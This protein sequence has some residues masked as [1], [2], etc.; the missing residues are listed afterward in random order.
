MRVSSLLLLAAPLLVAASCPRRDDPCRRKSSQERCLWLQGVAN[1]EPRVDESDHGREL[2]NES[3]GPSTGEPAELE[4][5]MTDVVEIMRFGLEWRLVDQRARELCRTR[6][7][8]GALVPADVTLAEDGRPAWTCPVAGLELDGEE[9]LLEASAGVIS[10]SSL[11]LDASR[12]DALFDL[13]RARFEPRCDGAFEELDGAKGEVFQRCPLPEGPF[14]IVGR[15]PRD[16][17]ADRWQVSI[18]VVDAG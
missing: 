8:D 18:A 11:E 4:R 16:R 2:G 10:L 7:E 1:P 15:F 5:V 3:G 17:E 12:S 6:D 9:L 13:A 14:L